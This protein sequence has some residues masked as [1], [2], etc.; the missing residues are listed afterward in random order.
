MRKTGWLILEDSGSGGPP[1]ANWAQADAVCIGMGGKTTA[2]AKSGAKRKSSDGPG[3][4]GVFKLLRKTSSAN[5]GTLDVEKPH[6]S[7]ITEWLLGLSLQTFEWG[8]RGCRRLSFRMGDLNAGLKA[9]MAQR[10]EA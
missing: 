5:L 6:Y 4:G 8:K 9:N 3:S 1:A 2:T 7:R 10:P